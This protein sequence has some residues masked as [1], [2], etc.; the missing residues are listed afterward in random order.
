MSGEVI[1]EAYVIPPTCSICSIKLVKL[2][3]ITDKHLRKNFLGINS[4]LA[5]TIHEIEAQ[6]NKKDD[7]TGVSGF[8]ELDK[9]TSGWQKTT[10]IPQPDRL[11]EKRP[12]P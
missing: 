2:H 9:V 11:L 7:L 5:K 12:S 10:I 1:G 8:R 6:N 3:E 4:I